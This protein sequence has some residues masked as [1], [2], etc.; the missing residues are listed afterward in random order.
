MRDIHCYSRHSLLYA[1]PYMVVTSRGYTKHYYNGSQRIA[2]R[3][4]DYWAASVAD[5]SDMVAHAREVLE[6][7][8]NS[9]DVE[10]EHFEERYVRSID[11]EEFYLEPFTLYTHYMTCSYSEDMLYE[12]LNGGARLADHIGGIDRG[13]FYYHPDHLGSSSWITDD[14]GQVV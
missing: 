11:G 13:I 9:E 7:T 1:N 3:L 14:R 8:M 5:E 2:A 10:E 4:G 6:Q 12:A